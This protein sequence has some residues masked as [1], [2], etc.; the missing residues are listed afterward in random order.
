MLT[1]RKSD[2]L[3]FV[4]YADVDFVGGDSRKSTSGYIFHPRWRSYIME[5][6]QTNYNCIVDNAGWVFIMLYVR[7]IGSMAKED[8]T[9]FKSGRQHFKT[10]NLILR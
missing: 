4:G 2:E 1:Y 7:W 8:C 5:K 3:K 10:T 6:L 9:Q